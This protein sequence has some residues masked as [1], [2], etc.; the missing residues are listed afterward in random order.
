MMEENKKKNELS[1]ESQMLNYWLE[2]Y[3]D[4]RNE[5]DRA[6][7][8]DCLKSAPVFLPVTPIQSDN[9]PLGPNGEK[10]IQFRMAILKTPEGVFL[11]PVFADPDQIPAE[12]RK[13]HPGG[14]LRVPISHVIQTL[15]RDANIQGIV[16][17]PYTNKFPMNREEVLALEEQK[18]A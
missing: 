11:L 9:L 8:I 7:V 3:K 5:K 12:E 18:E 10:Q 4:T 15:Q 2:R 14:F 17:D 6:S 16:V 1:A 13:K